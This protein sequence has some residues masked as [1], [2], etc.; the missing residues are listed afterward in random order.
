[1]NR[2]CWIIV[3]D[4]TPTSFRSRRR[5]TLLP[6]L[7]Q[8]QRT[9]PG[10]RLMWYDRGRFWRSAEEARVAL[11]SQ[12]KARARRAA[13]RG[14]D[15]RPGGEHKDPR[16]RPKLSRDARRA[17]FKKRLVSKSKGKDGP[18]RSADARPATGGGQQPGKRRPPQ[19][20]SGSFKK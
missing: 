3:V 1:M 9:Q 6:T 11:E 10:S 8:L 12:R 17:R 19:R 16:D 2:P 15:W 20:R 13:E 18:G 14:K 5:E 7:R 4:A